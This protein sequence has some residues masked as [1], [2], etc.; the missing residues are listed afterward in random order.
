MFL[1]FSCTPA[2]GGPD[3]DLRWRSSL[4]AE[5][6]PSF[7]GSWVTTGHPPG[8]LP[9]SHC[10]GDIRCYSL[11][12]RA[13]GSQVTLPYYSLTASNI[14]VKKTSPRVEKTQGLFRYMRFEK[15]IRGNREG[16]RQRP[17]NRLHR[18]H[19]DPSHAS[20]NDYLDQPHVPPP[21]THAHCQ[22]PQKHRHCR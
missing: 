16:Y 2:G 13:A 19:L 10:H 9:A 15:P 11:L 17:L 12:F 4:P 6:G 1:T 8:S 14:S 5:L 22:A 21:Q 7:T 20:A 3:G 18:R